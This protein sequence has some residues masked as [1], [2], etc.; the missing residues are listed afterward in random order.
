[1]YITYVVFSDIKHDDDN[2]DYMFIM[3]PCDHECKRN[4][5]LS[6]V[7]GYSV[8]VHTPAREVVFATIPV[9]Y[10]SRYARPDLHG[11]IEA[12]QPHTWPNRLESHAPTK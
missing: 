4:E 7:S 3:M 2:V 10:F 5:R 1:M 9:K 12:P 6:R 11:Q 8:A